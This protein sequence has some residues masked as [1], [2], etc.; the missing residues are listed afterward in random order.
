MWKI[1]AGRVKFVLL[2]RVLQEKKIPM[3]IY[4]VEKPFERVQI[5]ILGSLPISL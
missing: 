2:E 4:N 3:Q 1:D 5:D